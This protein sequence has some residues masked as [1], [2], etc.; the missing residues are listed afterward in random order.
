LHPVGQDCAQTYG[1]SGFTLRWQPACWQ[2]SCWQSAQPAHEANHAIES[3]FE[4]CFV[5]GDFLS[6]V[7][8]TAKAARRPLSESLDALKVSIHQAEA[9]TIM[10]S[11][12]RLTESVSRAKSL[13]TK[14][15]RFLAVLGLVILGLFSYYFWLVITDNLGTFHNVSDIADL[16]GDGDMDVV[17]H[18]VRTESEFTAFGGPSPW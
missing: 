7:C 4:I 2:W 8:I 14:L 16:D 15:F 18:N 12:K 6:Q 11:T 9:F 10:Q 5:S 3:R 17:I 1:A 13:F